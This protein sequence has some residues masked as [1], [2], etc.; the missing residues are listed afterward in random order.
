MHLVC[1]VDSEQRT[2][3]LA[4]IITC[5]HAVSTVNDNLITN[6]WRNVVAIL[7][8]VGSDY[9]QRFAYNLAKLQPNFMHLA[10]KS[11]SA[12]MYPRCAW[13][14]VFDA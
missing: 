2:T 4:P 14:A 6:Q 10:I 7:F 13:V 3:L 9:D 12:T 8:V 11:I 5:H 1:V